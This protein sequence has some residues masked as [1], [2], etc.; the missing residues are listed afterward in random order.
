MPFNESTL[1]VLSVKMKRS[2]NIIKIGNKCIRR[3]KIRRGIN[4]NVRKTKFV[5]IFRN[6][7][8]ILIQGVDI[9]VIRMKTRRQRKNN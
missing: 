6:F 4:F 5:S 8:L 3:Q 7:F 2:V 9:N 1:P